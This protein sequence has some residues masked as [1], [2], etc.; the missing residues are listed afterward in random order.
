MFLKSADHENCTVM[1]VCVTVVRVILCKTDSF[2][3]YWRSCSSGSSTLKKEAA[4]VA[5]CYL[6]ATR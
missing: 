1:F 4:N 3:I 6:K 2:D 5:T